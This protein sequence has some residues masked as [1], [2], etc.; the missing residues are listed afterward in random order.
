MHE[1]VISYPF[2]YHICLRLT[3]RTEMLETLRFGGLNER[4]VSFVAICAVNSHS[5]AQQ[6][7]DNLPRHDGAPEDGYV[8]V[9]LGFFFFY[10]VV[11]RK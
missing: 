4:K 6:R 8:V 7:S 2:R 11:I 9:V 3:V 5:K 10:V 1:I